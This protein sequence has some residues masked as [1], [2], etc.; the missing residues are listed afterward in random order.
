M[1]PMDKWRKVSPTNGMYI[2]VENFTFAC[3]FVT[4]KLIHLQRQ[5]D[6]ETEI[7]NQEPKLKSGEL[8]N[9]LYKQFSSCFPISFDNRFDLPSINRSFANPPIDVQ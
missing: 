6:R 7:H 1:I 5:C 2:S 4:Q 9:V 8:S 3:R